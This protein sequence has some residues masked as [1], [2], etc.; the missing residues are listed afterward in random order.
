MAYTNPRT[1]AIDDIGDMLATLASYTLADYTAA[2]TTAAAVGDIVTF[3]STGNFYV[4]VCPDNQ[5][6]KFGQVTKIEKAASGTA[7]GYLV[8]EWL[9]VVR[10]VE[11]DCDDATSMTLAN[12]AIKDGDT[13]VKDNFDGGAATGNLVIW[14]KSATSGAIK[15]LCAVVAA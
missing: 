4:K 10:F 5:V 14:A 15:A 9:D 1:Q 7:V 6:S 3:S 8:V 2:G 13:T 11:V 12:S